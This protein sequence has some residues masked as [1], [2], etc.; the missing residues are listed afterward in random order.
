MLPKE[1]QGLI[2]VSNPIACYD[3]K[4]RGVDLGRQ[5]LTDTQAYCAFCIHIVLP[6]LSRLFGD[7]YVSQNQKPRK[8]KSRTVYCR[9]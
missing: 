8:L 7:Q 4:L 5:S 2:K 3:Y 9:L 1:K 6:R